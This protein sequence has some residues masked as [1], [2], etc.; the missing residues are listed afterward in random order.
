MA[1]PYKLEVP[2]V[3]APAGQPDPRS[4]EDVQRGEGYWSDP[5]AAGEKAR[6]ETIEKPTEYISAVWADLVLMMDESVKGVFSGAMET[7][8]IAASAKGFSDFFD[9]QEDVM[10][11][12]Y[13]LE[14]PWKIATTPQTQTAIGRKIVDALN[15]L[16]KGETTEGKTMS[17]LD[18]HTQATVL[19]IQNKLGI[20]GYSAEEAVKKL[21]E[22]KFN[23]IYVTREARNAEAKAQGARE[24]IMA[25]KVRPVYTEDQLKEAK[26]QLRLLEVA[27][28]DLKNNIAQ[29][30]LERNLEKAR[31]LTLYLEGLFRELKESV[32]K[33]QEQ[34]VSV[35]AVLAARG[36]HVR[37]VEPKEEEGRTAAVATMPAQAVF[38]PDVVQ[39]VNAF[40]KTLTHLTSLLSRVNTA[41]SQI[42]HHGVNDTEIVRENFR[43]IIGVQKKLEAFSNQLTTQSETGGE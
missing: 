2:K 22:F 30:K 14:R 41:V 32:E 17:Q 38:T 16:V 26:E 34:A 18:E 6:Q 11:R 35:T 21:N 7:L 19:D 37:A 10:G 25:I 20:E 42:A 27:E 12:T 4:L 3:A 39:Q 24:L 13:F 9:K 15:L 23:T 8:D 31:D 33:A 36:V 43:I 29:A 5:Q 1:K 28:A 40:L